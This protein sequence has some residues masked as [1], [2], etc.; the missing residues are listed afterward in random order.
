MG[1]ACHLLLALAIAVGVGATSGL[2]AQAARWDPEPGTS[3]QIQFTGRLDTSLD[4]EVYDI[5]LWDTPAATIARLQRAGRRVI[6]YLSAGSWENWRPDA[7]RFPAATLG[8]P[9]DGWP[10]ERWLDVRSPAVRAI[11][12]DR[13]DLAAEKGCDAVDPDNVDGYANRTGFPLTA[14][15][16]LSFNRFLAEEAHARGLAVGL[17]N[18][19]EQIP[20]LVRWF[21]FAVNE[22][23]FRYD[24]CERLTPF[25]EAGK[26]VFQIEYG[27]PRLAPRICPRANALNFDTLIKNLRLDAERTPCRE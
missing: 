17:K 6:C 27:P 14:R 18:D 26:P 10:G 7:D 15:D 16:Q 2:P 24:E 21:D 1:K 4:V 22:E 19:V 5:D 9:L 12:R 8:R 23:C 11:V 25:I 3:W 20:S 13:F